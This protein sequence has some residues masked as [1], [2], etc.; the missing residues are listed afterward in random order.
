[1]GPQL[2]AVGFARW[3]LALSLALVVLFGV[4]SAG[5][6]FRPGASADD[7]TRI[8]VDATLFWGVFALVSGALGSLV[9]I[10]RIFQGMEAAGEFLSPMVAP[11]MLMF[12]L[13]GILGVGILAVAALLWFLLQLRW[14]LLKVKASEVAT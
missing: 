8:W 7:R 12:T 10:V 9:G 2:E 14:R 11:G 4:W 13:S 6:L 3:P 5:K 1:M